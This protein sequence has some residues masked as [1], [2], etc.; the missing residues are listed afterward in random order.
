[1]ADQPELDL[2][3][4]PP[5][6]P[7]SAKPRRTLIAGFT[8]MQVVAGLL[9]LAAFVWGMWV[10]KLL[11]APRQDHIVS[12]RL[13]AIVGDYVQAQARSAS[14]PE[15]VEAEMRKFMASL[16]NELQKRSAH[17]Q[18]VLVGE[19]VLTRNVPDITESIAKAVYASGVARPRQ[20][21]AADLERL[22]QQAIA[23]SQAQVATTGSAGPAPQAGTAVAMDSMAAAQAVPAPLAPQLAGPPHGAPA[24]AV[25]SFGGP[26]VP[27]DD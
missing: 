4:P 17:G 3:L 22:A 7:L 23:A 9:V 6:D 14:P 19:A 12:A 2:P 26:D 25:S 16:D 15:Q 5:P 10:T 21:S 18:I 13:S 27:G 20:A 1:M 24:A 8:R 11:V